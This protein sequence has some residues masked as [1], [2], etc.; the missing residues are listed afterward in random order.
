MLSTAPLNAAQN[1]PL[2]AAQAVGQ[3]VTQDSGQNAAQVDGQNDL[4]TGAHNPE[5]ATPIL[6]LCHS[7]FT[8]RFIFR[9]ILE[10][11]FLQKWKL[12]FV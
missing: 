5:R 8:D 4:Q 1:V 6:G 9:H 10:H 2:N 3:N 11:F 12:R 7:V